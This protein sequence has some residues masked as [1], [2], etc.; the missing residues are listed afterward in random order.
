[1]TAT[2]NEPAHPAECLLY[3]DP[4]FSRE[5]L[6]IPSGTA[7]FDPGTVLGRTITS[8]A[9]TA[10]GFSTNTASVGAVGTITVGASAKLGVHK[11][12]VVEP[13]TDAGTFIVFD[14]DGLVVGKGQVA[15][16][17]SAGGLTFTI[18]DAAANY[19]AGDGYHIT[20]TGTAKYV[21]YDDGNTDGSAIARAVA[22]YGCDASGG[23]AT[24]TALVRHAVVDLNRL[25]WHASVDATAKTKAVADL[26]AHAHILVRS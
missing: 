12:I 17:F 16:E 21:P 23:E 10:T 2:Y 3:E 18:A 19:A 4:Q 11:L 6:T 1:M 24:V 25:A 7:A 22:L 15:S 8:G 5:V 20:V 14:P 9:A 26:L 13:T